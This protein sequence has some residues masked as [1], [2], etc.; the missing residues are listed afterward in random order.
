MTS[1]SRLNKEM[2]S[3]QRCNGLF[4]NGAIRLVPGSNP[5]KWTGYMKGPEETPYADGVFEI[6]IDVPADYPMVPVQAS[7]VTQIFHPNV[8]WSTGEICL[9]ILKSCW[10]PAWTL[11][12]VSQ[13]IR[14]LLSHPA[15]DSPLNCDAGN[16]LRHSMF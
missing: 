4:D 8:Q 10:S 9:D 13:A 5:R 16:M 1:L 11:S 14:S 15:E 6:E 3:C 12:A 2:K 7:F